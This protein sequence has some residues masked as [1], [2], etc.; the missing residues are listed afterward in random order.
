MENDD[1]NGLKIIHYAI[2]NKKIW[3]FWT[4][5]FQ[6]WERGMA[7]KHI[8]V[9]FMGWCCKWWWETPSCG[10]QRLSLLWFPCGCP[11]CSAL[12]AVH[13]AVPCKSHYGVWVSWLWRRN[14]PSPN[15]QQLELLP[16]H[17]HLLCM[18][19][20]KINRCL[21]DLRAPLTWPAASLLFPSRLSAR[22]Q[23]R[24]EVASHVSSENQ[25]YS[26]ILFFFFFKS[27]HQ[28]TLHY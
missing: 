5:S 2:Q 24:R 19:F 25:V 28:G 22:D 14:P 18:R 27:R 4:I 12:V 23:K 7:L 6:P 16:A 11:P 10:S 17:H 15:T 21:P 8:I 20:I 9:M 1:L 3:K 26:C 13:V